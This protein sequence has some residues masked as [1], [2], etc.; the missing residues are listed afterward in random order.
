MGVIDFRRVAALLS[1]ALI[2]ASDR[3]AGKE[4]FE[5]VVATPT[6]EAQNIRVESTRQ[7]TVTVLY[8]LIAADPRATVT[9]V[10]EASDDAGNTYKII[11]GATTGDT[12]AGVAAGSAKRIVWDA[13][14]DVED[15][16]LDRLRF[17]VVTRTAPPRALSTLSRPESTGILTIVTAPSGA[18]I[19]LDG[20][21][22]GFAPLEIRGISA[23]QHRITATKAGYSEHT[24]L[25]KV[26]AGKSER[27]ELP[28]IASASAAGPDATKGGGALKWVLIAGGGGAAAAAAAAASGGKS[29]PSGAVA[30]NTPTTTST[31]TATT[32]SVPVNRAPNVTC[33][34]VTFGNDHVL[35]TG[36]V[37]VVSATRFNFEIA[38]AAD[39]D[40][41]ALSYTMI[42]GNGVTTTANYS[43]TAGNS[44]TYVYPGAGTFSP[45][46][47]VRDARGGE[48]GCRF[49]S[50][51]T[52]SVG[53]EWIGGPSSGLI[54][55]RL[56]LSQSGVTVTGNYYED[57]RTTANSLQ[58]TL[59]SN[60]AGSK[61]GSVT[62][63]VAGG[64]ANQ[65][66]FA[67]SPS[68][69]LRTYTGTYTY[70]GR[71]ATF[72]MQKSQ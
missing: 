64:F 62:L 47:T 53:G 40:G 59:V 22:L 25:V 54:Q 63:T 61:D 69:D 58:G 66:T 67:I 15:V 5:Q 49:P 51:V 1:V 48:G 28:M 10:L 72:A 65:L 21:P 9:V 20:R 8:D 34:N 23:G 24:R 50:I 4:P 29:P 52:S 27:L 12:G 39:A 18:Q 3:P 36:D 31:S 2:A 19:A 45:S 43:L 30:S 37:G 33:G 6:A 55:S 56:V 38:A 17:R 35:R 14:K 68:D 32:T 11:P 46:V 7:G 42:Y 41:D 26:E 60:R 71:T 57:A 70:R 16:Q 44:Q 13:A